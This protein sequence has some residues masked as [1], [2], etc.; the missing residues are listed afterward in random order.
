MNVPTNIDV[1]FVKSLF[2]EYEAGLYTAAS[3][4]GKIQFFFSTS[5]IWALF[6]K[7][8]KKNSIGVKTHRLLN[9][10]VLYIGLISG[11]LAVTYY[12]F[13]VFLIDI[14][15]RDNITKNFKV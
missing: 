5:M 4:F 11:L 13:P 1:I 3:I 9:R 8:S 12:F 10:A 15:G 6:P 14:L 2:T 7:V